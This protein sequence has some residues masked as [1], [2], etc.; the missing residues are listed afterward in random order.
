MWMLVAL[1]CQGGKVGDTSLVVET[2]APDT[3]PQDTAP[4]TETEDS[5]PTGETEDTEE[6]GET[7]ETEE[8]GETEDTEPPP[9]AEAPDYRLPGSYPVADAD[10]SVEVGSC[11]MSF[12]S[13][14]PIGAPDA[15]WLVLSHGFQ[16]S[17]ENVAE[18]AAHVSS[19]GVTVVTPQLCHATI[20]DADHEQN[21]VDLVALATALGAPPGTMYAGHSA[22]GLASLVAAGRDAAAGAGLGLDPVDTDDIGLDAAPSLS[23]PYDALLGEPSFCN[24]ERNGLDLAFAVASH[25][26]FAVTEADHCDFEAPTDWLCELGCWGTNDV[27]SDDEI[28]ATI[29]GMTTSWTLWRSGLDPAGAQWWT[30]GETWHDTLVATGAIAPK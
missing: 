22:G 11:E 27:F 17:S 15:P 19:W 20:F 29:A 6:T 28:R 8:T 13:Y 16:R 1:A 25:R 30:S 26:V 14:T 2:S 24:S 23:V 12:V 18:L 7:E 5:E 4:T 10:G 21:G 3:E 9:P